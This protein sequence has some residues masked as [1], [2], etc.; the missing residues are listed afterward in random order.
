L[1]AE[2]VEGAS[3]ALEGVDH[4]HGSD[5]LSLGVLGVGDGVANHVLQED[6]EHACL[7]L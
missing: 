4:V 1:A 6:F 3:L 7:C 5:R 2:A